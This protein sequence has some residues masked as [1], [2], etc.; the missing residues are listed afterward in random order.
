[1]SKQRTA[2]KAKRSRPAAVK[3]AA[4]TARVEARTTKT[5]K[6]QY[7]RAAELQGQTFTDFIETTLDEASARVHREFGAM[8]LSKRDSEAFVAALLA[9]A[10]PSRRLAAAA[11][12]YK[13]RTEA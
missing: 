5:K 7:M 13:E 9:D 10:A 11:E 6:A 8:E 12:R 3:R 4:K 2:S 1:M